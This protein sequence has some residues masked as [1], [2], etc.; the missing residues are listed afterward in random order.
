MP[1][2]RRGE[3]RREE[4]EMTFPRRPKFSMVTMLTLPTCGVSEL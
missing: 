1:A 2:R 4:V 3:E